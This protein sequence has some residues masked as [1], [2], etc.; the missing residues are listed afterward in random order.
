MLLVAGSSHTDF[1]VLNVGTLLT[2]SMRNFMGE[3]RAP[4]LF[5]E[6]AQVPV[7]TKHTSVYIGLISVEEASF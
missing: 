3:G 6:T 7:G 5:T 2:L 1:A 4:S